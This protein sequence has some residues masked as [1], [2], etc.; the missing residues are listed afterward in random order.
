MWWNVNR[1]MDQTSAAASMGRMVAALQPDVI[2]FSEVD[3][4]SANYVKG[5]LESWLPGTTW[6]VVKDDYDLMVASTFPLGESF[7]GVYRSFPVVVKPKS[8]TACPRSSPR[9]TLSVAAA[10]PTKRSAKARPTSTW[11]FTAMR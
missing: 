3:D 9:R 4:V 11:P 6:N 10:P 5:L 1:R 2:G 8:S 7:S